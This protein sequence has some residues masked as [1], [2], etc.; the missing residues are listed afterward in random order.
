MPN[1]YMSV[2]QSCLKMLRKTTDEQGK[3]SDYYNNY[4]SLTYGKVS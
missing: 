3:D 4:S 2:M 1:E